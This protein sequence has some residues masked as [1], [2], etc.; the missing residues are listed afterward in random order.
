MGKPR[1]RYSN[2]GFELLG[3]AIAGAAGTT[4]A[5]LVRDRLA[6]P[7]DLQ[8]FYVPATT[9]QLRAHALTG[10]T[11]WGT[12]RQP[13]TG[14]RWDQPVASVPASKTSPYSQPRCSPGSVP[15]VA[16]LDPVAAFG[17]GTRIGAGWVTTELKGRTLTWHN[18]SSGGFRS[19]LGLDRTAGTA[20]VILSATSASVDRHG[21][22]LLTGHT[23][24][25]G[26]R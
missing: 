6:S 14:K 3:H 1:V 11:R 16:A 4:F 17:S 15:G 22:A 25:A 13:W 19:W 8:C 18:G 5:D 7:L 23:P 24:V 20:V 9:G 10:Q 26:S 12:P 21:F 2:F